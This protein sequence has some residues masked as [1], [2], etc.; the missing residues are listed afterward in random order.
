MSFG[1][2]FN[3]HFRSFHRIVASIQCIFICILS[4]HFYFCTFFSAGLNVGFFCSSGLGM[5]DFL[6]DFSFF[7]LILSSLFC[8]LFF[9][10]FPFPT[11]FSR[12]AD[13]RIVFTVNFSPIYMLWRITSFVFTE[14][15]QT[16]QKNSSNQS[17]VSL[18]RDLSFL[19]WREFSFKGGSLSRGF[20]NVQWEF[21]IKI[22]T[23]VEPKSTYELDRVCWKL[24]QNFCFLAFRHSVVY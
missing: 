18:V 21:H 15:S 23:Q 14:P 16:F 17:R 13:L 12:L 3:S 8:S 20:E 10:L 1:L 11:C 5:C 22:D 7:N 9:H 24:V 6:T 4:F 2:I 19:T